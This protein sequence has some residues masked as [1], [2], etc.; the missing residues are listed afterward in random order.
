[1]KL[2]VDHSVPPVVIEST[3][4]DS[5][6]FVTREI[7]T[8]AGPRRYKL[9]IPSSYNGS[10]SMPLVVVLHGCT[11]DPDNVA[12]GTR[13]NAVAEESK[14]LVAYP[15][16][17]TAFNGLKC[18]NWFD[19]AHQK[20][21]QGEPALIAGITRQVMK[22]MNVDSH[23]VYIVGL[24]AGAA[25]ALTVS[26]AYPEIFAAMGLHSGIPYGVATST[27]EAIRRMGIGAS[28]PVDYAAAVVL[29]MGTNKPIPAIV[30]QGKSD[31]T[32][33]P[34]NA[35]NIVAQLTTGFAQSA[36]KP[37]TESSGLTTKGYHYTKRVF[38]SPPLIEQWS[39]DELGHAWSGGSREGTYTDEH[40]PD[41]TREIMRFL[42][43]HQH[44]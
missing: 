30:F 5:G 25:M 2:M 35:D 4:P 3:S 14:V 43:E 31:K 40:G 42:L 21:D 34:V 13:F 8:D 37:R 18:W 24:S 6:Q 17:P 1:M 12:R 10:S 20:R 16:Q 11:Q 23:R 39:V 33:N 7:Q 38:G 36:L 32:V 29:G 19:A 22:D 27:P 9:Y 15:E 44:A 26:Y 28:D 41:A